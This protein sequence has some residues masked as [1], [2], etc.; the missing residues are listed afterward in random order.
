MAREEE[1]QTFL[2]YFKAQVDPNDP[3]PLR[4]PVYNFTE[5]EIA[6]EII[7]WV[8][9]YLM[10]MHCPQYLLVPL[11]NKVLQETRD[12]CK[13]LP[14]LYGFDGYVFNPLKLST[15]V[16]SHANAICES[17]LDNTKLNE[18]LTKSSKDVLSRTPKYFVK[19]IKNTRRKM[20][21]RHICISDFNGMFNKNDSEPTSFYGVFDG[22]GGQ[23]AAVYTAAH[24]CYNIAKSLKYPTNIT[25]AIKDAFKTTDDA[26]IGKSE[27]HEL[28][29]GTTAIVCIYRAIE[30]RLHVGW[31]GDSQALLVCEGKVCQIVAPHVPSVESERDRVEKNGGV[32]INWN[33]SYRVNGVLAV[34]RAIGDAS[35]KPYVTSD[36]DTT[37]INLNGKEDFLI[38]ASDGLWESLTEDNIAILVYRH[39]A[40]NKG[41]ADSVADEIIDRARKGTSD[42]ITVVVVFFKDPKKIANSPWLSEM[43]TACDTNSTNNEI[44]NET[45]STTHHDYNEFH[46]KQTT[47]NSLINS[48]QDHNSQFGDDLGPETDV[49]QQDDFSA[50]ESSN[51]FQTNN[52]CDINLSNSVKSVSL[53]SKIMQHL[54]EHNKDFLG[55]NNP[56]RHDT[57][58]EN[59]SQECIDNESDHNSLQ[60]VDNKI[61]DA[62]ESLGIAKEEKEKCK[63]ENV[64]RDLTDNLA[65]I[66]PEEQDCF[67][68]NQYNIEIQYRIR[69][70]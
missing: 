42:N 26:F 33:G 31:V 13:K 51:K 6:G 19:E 65:I 41:C 23:D 62:L 29:S 37:C 8:Q 17:L 35:Y 15:M 24:L 5:D 55:S 32:V 69:N 30:K 45:Q 20:E 27:K 57:F 52:I 67:H 38:I 21:D 18:I 14:K 43:D 10:Q 36:P 54:S 48:D 25:G 58:D 64:T 46:D 44:E 11:V 53:E 28:S 7:H 59:K 49:D 1:Y 60:E 39:I 3:L 4:V 47:I 2:D 9:L 34:S 66:S 50:T 63:I 16:I 70:K 12:S 61:I 56:F 22:H 40:A 68:V